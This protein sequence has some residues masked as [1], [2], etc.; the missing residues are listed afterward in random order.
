MF[1]ATAQ[2]HSKLPAVCKNDINR[3]L[4][5]YLPSIYL[6]YVL[7]PDNYEEKF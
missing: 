2:E 5:Y 6:N 4:L 3:A 1:P 7:N